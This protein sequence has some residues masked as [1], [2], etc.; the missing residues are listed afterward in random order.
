MQFSLCVCVCVCVEHTNSEANIYQYFV[1]ME[2]SFPS[3]FIF[4]FPTHKNS[5]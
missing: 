4:S 1:Q 3:L 2:P 5:T